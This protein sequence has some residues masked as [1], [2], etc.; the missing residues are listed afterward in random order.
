M[1]KATRFASVEEMRESR[2][3]YVVD[4][5]DQPVGRVAVEAARLLR[6]K[7][8]TIY[9]P[10]VDC[11]DHV[12]IVNAA[13]AVLT[14]GNKGKEPIYHHTGWPGALKSVQRGAE[15]AATPQRTLRRVV[16]G[17]LPHTRLGDAMVRKLKVYSGPEH[18][19]EAQHPVPFLGTRKNGGE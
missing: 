2:V 6:G 11:G 12:I 10:N 13:K 9:T 18:P 5:A 4:A 16:R 8:K 19:H 17:M 1:A 3:W 14:G 7:H 15:L